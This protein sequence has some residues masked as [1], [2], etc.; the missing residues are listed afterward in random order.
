[1]IDAL[2][3]EAI[4][5]APRSL[6]NTDRFPR[7]APLEARERGSIQVQPRGT[8]DS[9]QAMR[10][11]REDDWKG[12]KGKGRERWI[13]VR[14]AEKRGEERNRS[15]DG[16][17]RLQNSRHRETVWDKSEDWETRESH[18]HK[19]IRIVAPRQ[20]ST[21][22]NSIVKT[23]LNALPTTNMALLITSINSNIELSL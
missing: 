7:A 14:L 6:R 1:M 8:S 12:E 10:S 23:T 21:N 3:L 16:Q 5:E 15:S 13:P 4:G 22:S 18:D 19:Y 9:S 17:R 20:S 11:A 2:L